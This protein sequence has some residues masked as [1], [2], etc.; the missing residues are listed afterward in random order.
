MGAL[1]K[2]SALI[3]IAGELNHSLSHRANGLG[4]IIAMK[5]GGTGHENVGA[6]Q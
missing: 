4:I 2:C 6:S 5:N 3:S 1:T